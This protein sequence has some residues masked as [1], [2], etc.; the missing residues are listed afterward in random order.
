MTTFQ[1]L[2]SGKTREGQ[3]LDSLT[4]VMSTAEAVSVGY[5]AALHAYYYDGGRIAADHLVHSLTG[6]ALKDTPE[7]LKKLE[8]YFN[9]VVKARQ[10]AHWQSYYAA[11]ACLP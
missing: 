11:R 5:A 3:S 9:H 10:G 6:S 1:E 7:D 8:H 2:R 4:T